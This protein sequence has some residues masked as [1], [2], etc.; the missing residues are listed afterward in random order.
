[1]ARGEEREYWACVSPLGKRQ[2]QRLAECS[3]DRMSKYFELVHR[4]LWVSSDDVSG[5]RSGL[6][7]TPS[8]REAGPVGTAI[9]D[10]DHDRE[11]DVANDKIHGKLSVLGV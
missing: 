8:G 4:C 11:S 6:G 2:A 10:R 5:D 7:R 9:K 1:M 3:A